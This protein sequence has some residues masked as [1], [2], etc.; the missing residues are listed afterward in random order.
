[1]LNQ[2]RAAVG[3]ELLN[4]TTATTITPI[5][6]HH[7]SSASGRFQGHT[8]SVSHEASFTGAL[9]AKILID[10]HPHNQGM[11]AIN[12]FDNQIGCSNG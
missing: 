9:C 5:S 1:M 12:L 7:L 8:M 10:A 3:T 4:N 11:D 2:R 6:Y